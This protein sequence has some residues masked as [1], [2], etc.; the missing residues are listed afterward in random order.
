MIRDDPSMRRTRIGQILS[1]SRPWPAALYRSSTSLHGKGDTHERDRW[2]CRI[3]SLPRGCSTCSMGR[4]GRTVPRSTPRRRSLH[5][6]PWDPPELAGTCCIVGRRSMTSRIYRISAALLLHFQALS[7]MLLSTLGAPI[8]VRP[9]VCPGHIKQA[10]WAE[11]ARN[12][13]GDA[14]IAPDGV[15]FLAKV[16]LGERGERAG[17]GGIRRRQ[18]WVRRK[19]VGAV[20]LH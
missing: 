2:A 7:S 20:V 5:R 3:A 1:Q 14:A 6:R 12:L 4:P 16:E 13:C 19:E 8:L 17:R 18:R 11:V 10:V 15:A 9:H